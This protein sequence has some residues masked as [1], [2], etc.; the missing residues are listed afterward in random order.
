MRAQLGARLPTFT[1]TESALVLGSSEFYGM[2]SYTSFYVRHKDTPP[3]LTD[4]QGNIEKLDSNNEGVIRGPASDTY[5]LRTCPWGLRKLLNWIWNRYHVPIYMTENGTT[6]QGEHKGPTEDVLH[7]TFRIDF[8]NGYINAVATA[9]KEDGVDIR[10]YF[11]WTF[12]DNWGELAGLLFVVT[13]SLQVSA[14]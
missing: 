9:V 11:G 4:H 3:E 1:P 12:T 2:N 5:W 7:D 8:F 14:Y 13:G 10:S 6:A